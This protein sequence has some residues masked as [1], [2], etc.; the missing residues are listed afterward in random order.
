MVQCVAPVEHLVERVAESVGTRK[1]LTE[2]FEE[3]RKCQE[4]FRE[5]AEHP[6]RRVAKEN[7]TQQVDTH[8]EDAKIGAGLMDKLRQE[9]W[10]ITGLDLN[11]KKSSNELQKNFSYPRVQ[12]GLSDETCQQVSSMQSRS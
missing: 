12:Q 10:Q 9:R 6:A 8:F 3:Y 7:R 11:A 5:V 1:T 4:W 2:T